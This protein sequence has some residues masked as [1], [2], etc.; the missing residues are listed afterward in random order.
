MSSP[1]GVLGFD[2]VDRAGAGNADVEAFDE[3]VVVFW[4][5]LTRARDRLGTSAVMGVSQRDDFD[6]S[7]VTG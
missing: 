4:C 2:G 6:A 7:G 5:H 3:P 1:V